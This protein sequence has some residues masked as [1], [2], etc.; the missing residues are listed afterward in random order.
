MS[1]QLTPNDTAPAYQMGPPWSPP[2]LEES[3]TNERTDTSLR[4]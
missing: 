3:P 1:P 4:S 2:G